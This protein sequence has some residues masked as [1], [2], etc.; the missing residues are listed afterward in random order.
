MTTENQPGPGSASSSTRM[1]AAN[2]DVSV[3]EMIDAEDEAAIGLLGRPSEL[4][5]V[6]LASA[7]NDKK[8]AITDAINMLCDGQR[9]TVRVLECLKILR[10]A[11]AR[12][13]R[14]DGPP[15]DSGTHEA[16]VGRSE[17]T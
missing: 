15:R 1:L 6:R 12:P 2:H 4:Q 17:D 11:N 9:A 3:Q 5:F 8:Q 14:T 7:Y 10:A 13:V 16:V